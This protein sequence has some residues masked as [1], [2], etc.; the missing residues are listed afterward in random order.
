MIFAAI[1]YG[2]G[3]LEELSWFRALPSTPVL[4]VV[5]IVLSAFLANAAVI[6]IAMPGRHWSFS[7]ISAIVMFFALVIAM[8]LSQKFPIGHGREYVIPNLFFWALITTGG[9]VGLF[10]GLFVGR[11]LSMVLGLTFGTW[12]G[13][14]LSRSLEHDDD[15]WFSLKRLVIPEIATTLGEVLF[16]VILGG[17]LMTAL[18]LAAGVGAALGAPPVVAGNAQTQKTRNQKPETGN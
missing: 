17:I 16:S 11:T 7:F 2:A 1:V 8:V 3:R 4:I 14:L 13:Y 5:G 12:M 15:I 6:P 18:H 10:Y 9:C